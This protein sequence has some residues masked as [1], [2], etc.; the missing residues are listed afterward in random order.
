[1]STKIPWQEPKNRAL[2][3]LFFGLAAFIQSFIILYVTYYFPINNIYIYIFV[4][5]GVILFLTGIEVLFAQLIHSLRIYLWQKKAEKKKVGLKKVSMN[6]SIFV[7][8]GISLGLYLIIYFIFSYY[9][10]DPF[11]LINFPIY[12]KFALIEIL[13]GIVVVVAVGIIDAAL[14]KL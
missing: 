10:L 4:P 1:M 14:P 12:G 11:S 7:G 2:V 13:S 9:L 6:W 5:L 8:A 3:L